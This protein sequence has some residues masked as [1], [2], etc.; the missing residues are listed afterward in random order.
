MRAPTLFKTAA[1]LGVTM[2]MTTAC[3]SGGGNNTSGG[4]TPPGEAHGATLTIWT[5]PDQGIMDGLQ[6]GPEA[7]AQAGGLTGKWARGTNINQHL[8]TKIQAED[9]PG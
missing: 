3:L 1:V 2:A 6:K 7:M 8:M 4:G 9:T 5:S